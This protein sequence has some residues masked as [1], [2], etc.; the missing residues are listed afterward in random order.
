MRYI[1]SAGYA[2]KGIQ[3]IQSTVD[4]IVVKWIQCLRERWSSTPKQARDF[5][6][7]KRIQFLTVDITTKL[8]LGESFRCVEED[9]DQHAFL[10][11]VKTA[12][13]VSLQLSLFPELTRTLYHLTKLAP[14]RR[15]LVPSAENKSG[16]GTVMSVV[17]KVIS[18]WE[19]SGMT[20]R[21]MLGSFLSRGLSRDQ[22]ETELVV[23]LVA[24]SDTTSTAVQATLLTIIT[25]PRVY[26]KL[27]KEIDCAVNHRTVSVPIQEAEARQLPYLQACIQEGLRIHPPLAQL[28]D[29]VAPPEGDYI[30]GYR[31][32][33]GTSVGFNSWG[34]QR[35]PIYGDDAAIF[36]PERWVENEESKIK[37]MKQ[38]CDLIFGHGPTKCLG[39]KIAWMILNKAIFE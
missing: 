38:V 35:D 18:K 32:P 12:T 29:R 6:V 33:G 10:D 37:E 8:C 9:R 30:H 15:L 21:D 27:Q 13:P 19:P 31:V 11:T 5:D 28:R 2:G 36:R 39:S 14:I 7:G 16:I 4:E 17:K 34:T 20:P 25:N 3:D 24:G 1:M 23:S 26:H 22:A